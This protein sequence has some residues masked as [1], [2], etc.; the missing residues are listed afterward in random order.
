M[1]SMLSLRC[2]AAEPEEQASVCGIL[3]YMVLWN[4]ELVWPWRN[5][6]G[7]F[8]LGGCFDAVRGISPEL[9]LAVRLCNS[10]GEDVLVLRAHT[11]GAALAIRRIT[12][13]SMQHV[14]AKMTMF[15]WLSL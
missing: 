15:I 10:S 4:D 3:E 9:V 14:T 12:H 8:L 11:I 1:E 6:P 5:L 7:D 13:S 2:T